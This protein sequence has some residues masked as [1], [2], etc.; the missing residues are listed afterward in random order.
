MLKEYSNCFFHTD[1]SQ[2]IGKVPLSYDNVDLVTGTPHKFYG[3]NG[4]GILIKK[5]EVSLKPQISGGKST[6]V[7]RSGTPCLADI[8]SCDIALDIALKE[9]EKRY[10]YIKELSDKVK[11]NLQ[12]YKDVHINNTHNSIPHTINFSI[13][14]V[15]AMDIQNALEKC[16][17]YVSTKTSCCS[18]NTPSK[19]LYALT[20]D[21]SLSTSSIRLS[22][23]H[24]TTKEEIEEFLK[25][26]DNIYK[27]YHNNGKI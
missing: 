2:A 15:R 7:Y 9:Q 11:A 25:V 21:K 6:T 20:K 18:V 14:K 24:L 3:L 16:D 19:L 8:A 17:I 10:K 4:T 22:I 27:E 13:K 1:A 5:K 23:S 26:F 12:E